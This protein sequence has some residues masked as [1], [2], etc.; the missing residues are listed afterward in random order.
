MLIRGPRSF[1]VETAFKF[2]IEI[3]VLPLRAKEGNEFQI[4]L[5]KFVRI[6]VVNVGRMES[7]LLLL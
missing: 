2:D 6:R 7:N 4:R 5:H 3:W 1:Y